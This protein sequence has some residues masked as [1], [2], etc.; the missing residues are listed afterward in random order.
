MQIAAGC[1]NSPTV[2]WASRLLSS[3]AKVAVH[4]LHI[5][6][7][8]M[9][10]WQASPMTVYHLPG[11]INTMADLASH[12]FTAHPT[13]AAFLT[14]FTSLFP[15]PQGNSWLLCHLPSSLSGKIYSALQT[16]TSPLAWWLQTTN[17]ATVI[18]ATGAP[19]SHPILTHTY[20]M[21]PAMTRS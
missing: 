9:L 6:A 4:L 3:W 7:L 15:L 11:A 20:K 2:A 5:L 13:N 19:L 14:H 12:S 1:D 10:T 17:N 18:G 21:Q 8:R 16:T